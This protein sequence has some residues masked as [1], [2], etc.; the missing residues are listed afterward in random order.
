MNLQFLRY[1]NFLCNKK[2]KN[3]LFFFSFLTFLLT[4]LEMIGLGLIPISIGTLMNVEEYNRYLPEILI[5]NSFINKSQLD[6]FIFLSFIIIAIFFAKNIFAFLIIFFE[7]KLFRNIKTDNA[8][9]LYNLYVNLP[10]IHHYNYNIATIMKNVV[11]ESRI[12]SEFINSISVVI[13][14]LFLFTGLMALMIIFNPSIAFSILLAGIFLSSIYLLVI[15]KKLL[16]ETKTAERIREYQ[17]KNINQVFSSLKETRILNTT[18]FFIKEFFGKTFLH[19][20]SYF[21]LNIF[22]RIP[23]LIFEFL[24]VS[25]ILLFSIYLLKRGYNLESLLPI[26]GLIVVVA[27]RLLPSFNAITGAITALKRYE[28]SVKIIMEEFN[29]FKKINIK[30]YNKKHNAKIVN[31][32]ESLKLKDISFTFP[33]ENKNLFKKLQH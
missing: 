26:L 33:N 5:F 20:N 23:K 12:S 6:Q 9:K 7:G 10:I 3:L 15:K 16:S 4:L 25:G 1:I 28:V 27:V 32:N 11:A 8:N 21:I 29:K 13:R 30:D 22:N 2:Q 18:K 17:I 24:V 31:F 19:E 14:E